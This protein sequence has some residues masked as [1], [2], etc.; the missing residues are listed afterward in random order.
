MRKIVEFVR[1]AFHCKLQSDSS[2]SDCVSAWPIF[3]VARPSHLV[4]HEVLTVRLVSCHFDMLCREDLLGI[5][6]LC[7]LLSPPFALF[8]HPQHSSGGTCG[9]DNTQN[10]AAEQHQLVRRCSVIVSPQSGCA[11]STREAHLP[12]AVTAL[13]GGNRFA[14]TKQIH[15]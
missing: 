14:E 13:C 6:M 3:D 5:A 7:N 8:H 15:V 10:T 1:S 9:A 12:S 4:R 2:D 11:F